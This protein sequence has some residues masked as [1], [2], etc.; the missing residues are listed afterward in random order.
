MCRPLRTWS[1]PTTG[2]LFSEK[3]AVSQAPQPVQRFKST[4]IAKR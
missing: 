2:V 4:A 3:Q 1:G